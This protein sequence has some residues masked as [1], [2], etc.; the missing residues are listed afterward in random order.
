MDLF[1]FGGLASVRERSEDLHV[2]VS[3]LANL[4]LEPEVSAGNNLLSDCNRS[5]V[6]NGRAELGN[7]FILKGADHGV[8]V[9]GQA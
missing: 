3:A 9:L 6:C 1:D 7:N 2:N 4:D 5:E 8:L